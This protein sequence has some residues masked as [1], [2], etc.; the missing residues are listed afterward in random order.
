MI[1]RK[2]AANGMDYA[3]HFVPPHY[4]EG[5]QAR[6]HHTFSQHWHDAVLSR[7][8]II[9][10]R[11]SCKQRSLAVLLCRNMFVD[12]DVWLSSHLAAAYTMDRLA[13]DN[14]PTSAARRG[15]NKL[16]QPSELH[17][18]P[19]GSQNQGCVTFVDSR[20]L[21]CLSRKAYRQEKNFMKGITSVVMAQAR[22]SRI[23]SGFCCPGV[24]I[25]KYSSRFHRLCG[26]WI[27]S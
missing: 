4:G 19:Y 21:F 20:T 16:F 6:L 11:I 22:N 1:G 8:R 27:V 26:C 24:S 9:R 13:V 25:C 18:L 10:E 23:Q 5:A 7:L 2:L 17:K 3:A 15:T 12:S 14:T